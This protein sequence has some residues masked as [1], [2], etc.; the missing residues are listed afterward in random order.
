M[1]RAKKT[2]QIKNFSLYL[3]KKPSTKISLSL[4]SLVEV[5]NNIGVKHLLPLVVKLSRISFIL[6]LQ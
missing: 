5:L 1:V 3:F 6:K 2:S 4:Y